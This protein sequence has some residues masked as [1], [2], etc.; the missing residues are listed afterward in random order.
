MKRKNKN[1]VQRNPVW[2]VLIIIF[3]WIFIIFLFAA[4]SP[5]SI[6]NNSQ[7]GTSNK[8]SMELVDSYVPC[9][10]VYYGGDIPEYKQ[11]EI[12]EDICGDYQME[13]YNH[14]CFSYL[15]CSCR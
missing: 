8:K 7:D 2:F 1:W 3:A 5:N 14:H 11:I 9:K 4:F 6:Y 13:Y 15:K 10:G 12:C